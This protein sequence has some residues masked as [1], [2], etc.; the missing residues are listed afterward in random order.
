MSSNTML[1]QAIIDANALR[2]VALKNAE[3][4]VV[5]KYSTQIKE[6]VDNML[7][8]EE[9]GMEM[10]AP[11]GGP[12][13][14]GP[15]SD[16]EKQASLSALDGEKLCPCPDEG[17][18]IEIDFEDLQ[19]IMADL[20][21]DDE[22]ALEGEA[23][24]GPS[25]EEVLPPEEEE[26]EEGLPT[27]QEDEDVEIDLSALLAEEDDSSGTAAAD[28]AEDEA[29]AAEEESEGTDEPPPVIPTTNENR[30]HK[31]QVRESLEK[32]N[33]ILKENIFLTKKNSKI[34]K[35]NSALI[36]KQKSILTENK[37]LKSILK[38]LSAT[39]EESNL[40]NAKLIYTNRVLTSSSLNE[41]QKQRI[42]EAISNADSVEAAK[43]IY[44]TLQG[45][46][47]SSLKTENKSK[48]L[49]EAIVRGNATMLRQKQKETKQ[50]PHINRMKKLAGI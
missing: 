50:D 26:E 36:T 12:A 43:S 9:L 14:G 49:S 18:T 30:K 44:E 42:A 39:L 31:R 45:A 23:L 2:E 32:N 20:K 38:K 6:A 10:D 34:L 24:P 46:V 13:P 21:D 25:P 1:K 47:G 8:Q 37:D 29:E 19:K 7:E 17:S 11:L 4:I 15:P 3:S 41:R 5:E 33:K 27:L 16:V 28:A 48:S 35:E 22:G 40:S